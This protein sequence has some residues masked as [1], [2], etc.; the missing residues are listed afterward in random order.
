MILVSAV[1]YGGRQFSKVLVVVSTWFCD[2]VN[3]SVRI[4]NVRRCLLFHCV[5]GCRG[6]TRGTNFRGFFFLE[7]QF[8]RVADQ[9]ATVE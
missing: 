8:R 5:Q 2:V 3:T 1:S 4:A 9:C 7:R 6:E